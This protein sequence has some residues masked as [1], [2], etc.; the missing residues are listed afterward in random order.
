MEKPH[1]PLLKAFDDLQFNLGKKTLVDFIKGDENPTI[2]RNNLDELNSYG[3]LYMVDRQTIFALIEDLIKH[4]FLEINTVGTGF[5]V[6]KRTSLGVKEVF[7][8]NHTPKLEESN[9]GKISKFKFEFPETKITDTDKTLF[10]AFSFFLDKFNEKQKKTIITQAKSVLCI[11]G[12]GSGKTTVLTKRIEFLTKFKGV[13]TDKVLAITFTRKAKQEMESRLYELGIDDVCVET[14]NSYCEKKLKKYGHKIYDKDVTVIQYK[15]K[16]SLVSSALKKLGKSFDTF[17]ENYFNKRQLREKSRDE[18][19]FIFVNDVFSIIDYYKNIEQDISKFYENTSKPIEKR[20]AQIIYDVALDVEKNLKLKGV[21][22]FSDQV[23]DCLTLFRQFPKLIPEYEHVLV[24]EFQ[25]VNLIQNEFIKLLNPSNLF[26]VGDPRQA[27]YGWRGSEIKF[28]LDFPKTFT[29]TEVIFL[30]TNY[31]SEKNIVSIANQS[32]KEFGLPDMK[33]NNNTDKQNIYLIEQD[34]EKLEKT[35]VIG[36]IKSSKNP[37]NEIF[38]L[39]RTNRVLEN[40]A[41]DFK[42]AG[43]PYTIKSEEE[44]K[45]G[46]PKENEIVLATIH[47][48]K[49]MEAKE[50]YIVSCNSISFPNKVVDNFVFS[51]VKQDDDY[52]KLS[53]ELRLFYVAITRAKEKLVISYTGNPSKFI[54]DEMKTNII[55]KQKNKNLF[56]F[57]N[58][59]IPK[60]LDSSNDSVLLNMLKDFRADKAKETGLPSY[61]IISNQ[62]LEDLS[63]IKPSNKTEMMSARGMGS[64][65]VAKYGD[66]I[67]KIING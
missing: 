66:E 40:Y 37:R 17:Y 58:K 67:L 26:V 15:N 38:V 19:F 57:G 22:D 14:F 44:Y 18:L 48:I 65:K 51:M 30:E 33:S 27:I 7:A 20:V 12:A 1:I 39:A 4:K 55:I 8:K 2:D 61:M 3:C 49:G 31:R 29:E 16:I 13:S 21:R 43:I 53:E 41:Q 9:T 60:T 59:Y 5:Q 35:F 42:K 25:D 23:I 36:A 62:A 32:I 10:S 52:D 50:V 6:I 45:S 56:D 34:N 24:D 47:S 46:E 54:T 63:K 28:I 64:M 11:A